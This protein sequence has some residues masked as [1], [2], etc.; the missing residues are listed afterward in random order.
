M[1]LNYTK[2]DDIGVDTM[3]MTTTNNCSYYFKVIVVGEGG[4]G[5]TTMINRYATNK[6]IESSRMT[7][8]AAFYS[9]DNEINGGEEKIRLQVWDFGG[10][11]RF[12]FVLPRYC[13][14]THGVIYAFDLKRPNSL[15]NLEDWFNLVNEHTDNEPTFLLIGTK[16]DLIKDKKLMSFVDQQISKFLKTHDLS[17]DLFFKTSSLLGQN[18]SEVFNKISNLLCKRVEDNG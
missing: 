12:R 18:I 8:G 1:E 15:W 9:F 4:V 10:E 11:K 7:I 5:K 16:A 2:S 6:F 14:G 17:P 3:T 13:K